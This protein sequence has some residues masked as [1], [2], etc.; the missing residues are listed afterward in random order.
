MF[1]RAGF[2]VAAVLLAFILTLPLAAQD[3]VGAPAGLGGR[4]DLNFAALSPDPAP[5]E[6]AAPGSWSVAALGSGRLGL[7]L[8][9]GTKAVKPELRLS[10]TTWPDTAFTL[11]RA[12]VKFRFPGLRGTLGL[13][14]IGWGPALVLNPADLL[15]DSTSLMSSLAGDE[16]RSAG[17]WLA[18][19]WIAL[20]DESFVEA[21]AVVPDPQLIGPTGF[22]VAVPAE[23]S[24]L[25][26][27]L[28]A[29]GGSGAL[30]S[31]FATVLDGQAGVL[32]TAVSVQFHAG[33]DW[34]LSGKL[35]VPATAG[36]AVAD[37]DFL[38]AGAGGFGVFDLGEGLG[39]STRHEVLVRPR[40]DWTRK[41]A[42][43]NWALVTYHDLGLT[44]PDSW[45]ATLRCLLSPL[46]PSAL[47]AAEL[48]WAPLQ[49]LR[50]RLGAAF[51][52]GGAGTTWAWKGPG[53]AGVSIGA[54]TTW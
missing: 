28:R 36:I 46:E 52:L 20:G 38:Q 1:P 18:D 32:R 27:G 43:G 26:G 24:H 42:S 40:L 11:D 21:L 17:K 51:R 12:W 23:I 37:D 3:A 15:F 30:S 10:W 29:S 54:S 14:R 8:G 44:L 22:Q 19:C 45:S 9:L 16:L 2:P 48:G 34:Y 31:E 4:L 50:F 53:A 39:L 33:L 13:G 49:G 25:A 5:T 6:G 47:L 41:S 7:G 35:T